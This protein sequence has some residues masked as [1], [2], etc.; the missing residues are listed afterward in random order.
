MKISNNNFL[1]R[2]YILVHVYLQN[3]PDFKEYC[4]FRKYLIGYIKYLLYEYI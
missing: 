3:D 2:F 1:T 4:V